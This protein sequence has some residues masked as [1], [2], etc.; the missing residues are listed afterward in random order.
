MRIVHIITRF[1]HGGADEN[2]LLTCN[3]QAALDHEVHLV[4]GDHHPDMVAALDPGVRVH[5]LDSLRR[6]PTV[7]DPACLVQLTRLLRR[8]GP[9]IVH[10]HESKAG[11]LGR[12]AAR[13]AGVKRIVHGVHILP[14]VGV[15]RPAAAFYLALEKLAARTTHAYV[16]VSEEMR[17][18]CLEKR[19]GSA[20]THHVVASGMD[21]ARFRAAVPLPRP[22]IAPGL[23]PDVPLLLLASTLEP[24]KRV[25]ELVRAL[26]E[27]GRDRPWALAVAGD[28]A[29]RPE[30][31][32]LVETLGLRG[33]V[34]LLGFRPD[35]PRLLASGDLL[36]HAAR[37]E[38]LPRVVV[39]AVLAGLPVASTALPG[40]E[41]VVED[42]VNGLLS[43]V[44]SIP[45]LAANALR[46]AGDPGLRAR[47]G[48]AARARDL[49]AWD[50]SAMVARIE[51][52]YA[53]LAA[54][55][56]A[57]APA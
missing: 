30:L 7:R 34:F 47:M 23:T 52:V 57:P 45:G 53:G 25:G 12:L 46:L 56:I 16:D 18:L 9:D 38:G 33:R 6:E 10:T 55:P 21:V 44:E 48:A 4:I 49:S 31:E 36:V 28:G 19:L 24:R 13:L 14:F 35:L 54:R 39:Q 43:P 51:A 27:A 8:L 32:G 3:G 37:N 5:H 2:T 1:I 11:I 29:G 20:E 42:G 41:A 17:R 15:S 40:V 26:A 50:A 22:E